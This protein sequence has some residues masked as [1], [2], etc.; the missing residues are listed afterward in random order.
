LQQTPY[1]QEIRESDD[2]KHVLLHCWVWWARTKYKGWH[3]DC[4][5]SVDRV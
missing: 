3:I 5:K 2:V 4:W 1:P